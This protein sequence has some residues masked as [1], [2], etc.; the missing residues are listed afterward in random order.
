MVNNRGVVQIPAASVDNFQDGRVYF[1]VLGFVVC[2]S[3]R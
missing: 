2:G 3:R 1:P